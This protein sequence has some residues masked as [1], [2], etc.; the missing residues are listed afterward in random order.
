MLGS[1]TH[2]EVTVLVDKDVRGLE[3]TMDDTGRVDVL[4]PAEDLV[5]E[6]LDELLLKWPAGEE[7]VQVGTQKLSDK[8]AATEVSELLRIAHNPEQ[9]GAKVSECTRG[10]H[11]HVLQGRNE[12]VTERDDLRSVIWD[13][14]EETT[15]TKG[16]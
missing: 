8:V 9:P 14:P 10:Y 16:K 5:E 2:L 1:T 4:E 3:I 11:S 13:P 15:D 6:V 12:D 7:T